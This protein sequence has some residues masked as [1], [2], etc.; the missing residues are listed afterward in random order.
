ME[1]I[2][3]KTIVGR[4]VV[5]NWKLQGVRYVCSYVMSDKKKIS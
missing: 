2:C 1:F 4:V 3:V 5:F